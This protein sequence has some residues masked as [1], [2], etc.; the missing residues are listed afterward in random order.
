MPPEKYI[1]CVADPADDDNCVAVVAEEAESAE[2][3]FPDKF[4]L[5]TVAFKVP[6]EGW[7]DKFGVV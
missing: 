6:V 7:N 2:V 5:N 3:A 4:P 1:G